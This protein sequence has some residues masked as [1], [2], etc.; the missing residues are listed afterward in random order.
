MKK[1]IHQKS[2]D[3]FCDVF[4]ELL[5]KI[6]CLSIPNIWPYGIKGKIDTAPYILKSFLQTCN[7][8]NVSPHS[9][10]ILAN[11]ND[12]NDTLKSGKTF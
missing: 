3:I 4:C 9:T 2:R 1:V 7:D 6:M 5:H 11:K 10:R 12:E 8:T